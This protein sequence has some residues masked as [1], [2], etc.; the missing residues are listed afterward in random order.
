MEEVTN[1]AFSLRDVYYVLFR[2]KISIIILFFVMLLTIIV[3]IYIWPEKYEAKAIIFVKMGRENI[4]LS[5]VPPSTQQQVMAFSGVRKEDINSE[6][7]ILRNRFIIEKT[8]NELGIDFFFPKAVKPKTFLKRVKYELRGLYQKVKNSIH[9]VLYKLGLKKR[10]SDYENIVLAVQKSLSAKQV[11]SSDVIEVNFRW[12]NPE[13]ATMALD[14]L[15]KFY[16]EHH[17]EAHKSSGGHEFFQKQV[18][19]IGKSLEETEN[20]LEFLKKREGITSFQSQRN[21]VLG[22]LTDFQASLKNTQTELAET[23]SK[24]GELKKQMSLLVNAITP[25]FATA[26]KEAEKELLLHEVRLTSLNAKQKMLKQHVGSYQND[27]ER[28]NLYEVEL[29]RLERQIQI[30]EENYRLYRKKLEETRI[31]DVLDNERI[32]NVRVIDPPASSFIP[33]GPRKLLVI[34]IGLLASLIIA[35]GYAVVSEYLDHSIKTAED[36]KRHLDLS[37]LASF[38]EVKK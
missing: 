19:I 11:S 26:Y 38:K 7:E 37:L 8:V 18:N 9:K 17:L 13:I 16:M 35:V 33:V 27:L 25:A 31:F 10:L 32:V 4:T 22:K 36:V 34:G 6:I 21:F 3:G 28:L 15:L 23:T 20:R 1:N 2:H 30:D 24:V 29:K 5:A 12:F 14:S